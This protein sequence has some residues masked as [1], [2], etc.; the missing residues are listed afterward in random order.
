MRATSQDKYAAGSSK[1]VA[2][3]GTVGREMR[4]YGYSRSV[5]D[6]LVL[7]NWSRSRAFYANTWSHL[8]RW[9]DEH[10]GD[11]EGKVRTRHSAVVT[12]LVL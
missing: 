10:L 12:K 11:V 5:A 6:M 3:N 1:T 7:W 8:P 2:R 9:N 4:G